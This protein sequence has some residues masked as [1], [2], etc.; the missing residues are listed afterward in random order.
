M[1]LGLGVTSMVISFGTT[2]ALGRIPRRLLYVAIPLVLALV[3]VIARL[4]LLTG[5]R[6]LYP[7]LWLGKEI[8]NSLTGIMIWGIA[9]F[10][11]DTRQAKRLF[12]LFNASRILGQVVGGFATGLLVASLGIENLLLAWAAALLLAFVLSRTILRSQPVLGAPATPRQKPSSLIGPQQSSMSMK[13][14]WLRSW[15]SSTGSAPPP[16]SWPPCFWQT[17]SSRALGSCCVS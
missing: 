9:G 6:W 13:I 16:R 14:A 8:L 1:F 7:V 4:A 3:L 2:A 15:G 11:C 5:A 12:P 17:G 10:V